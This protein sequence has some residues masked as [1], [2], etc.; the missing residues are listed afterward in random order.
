MVWGHG[1]PSVGEL[2]NRNPTWR[3]YVGSVSSR[4]LSRTAAL[5]TGVLG[6]K[7]GSFSCGEDSKSQ[8]PEAGRPAEHCSKNLA[9]GSEQWEHCSH[10]QRE[11]RER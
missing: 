2:V 11:Q 1:E 5:E 10:C 8:R 6:R 9:L 7:L 3:D 4:F